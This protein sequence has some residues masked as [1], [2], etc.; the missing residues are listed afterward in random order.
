[1]EEK[2]LT[3][4]EKALKD[5]AQIILVFGIICSVIVLITMCFVTE[6]DYFGKST[7]EF[8]WIGI[9]YVIC[10][11]LGTIAAWALLT[12]LAEIAYS[13]RTKPNSTEWQKEFSLLVILGKK[14][15]A[16]EILYR[17]ILNS[18][19]MQQILGDGN[20]V[21]RKGR[22]EALLQEYKP[23]LNAIGENTFPIDEQ[24]ILFKSFS[25]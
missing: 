11:V 14:E 1:M 10:S 9:P 13:V 22:Y 25:K 4:A 21:Y 16:K 2:T 24:S 7:I 12:I 18:T 17:S 20:E 8:N 5:I 15:E 6:K 23:Y 3:S 19:T